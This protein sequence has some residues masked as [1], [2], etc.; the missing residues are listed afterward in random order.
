MS[1]MV[2]V[3][4]VDV[5]LSIFTV[6]ASESK[7]REFASA[8]GVEAVVAYENCRIGTL[9]FASLNLVLVQRRCLS[10]K[11]LLD[12]FGHLY[13]SGLHGL[14]LACCYCL[15]HCL[16]HDLRMPSVLCD[17]L[18]C[19]LDLLGQFDTCNW[20]D[21]FNIKDNNQFNGHE[22]SQLE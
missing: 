16:I 1:L 8:V 6:A 14:H 4:Q 10:Q 12:F 15:S 18:S 11:G 17:K 19:L 21:H 5:Q 20:D 7:F 2:L 9:H 3:I 22:H 13:L